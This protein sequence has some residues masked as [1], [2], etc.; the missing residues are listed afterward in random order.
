LLGK[1]FLISNYLQPY[2]ISNFW[3]LGRSSLDQGNLKEIEIGLDPFE[4]LFGS[5]RVWN[6]SARQC[7][8]QARMSAPHRRISS[9]S[10]LPPTP[11]R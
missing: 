11:H 5:N 6:R 1:L 3:R 9:H 8:A 2:F 7:A 10:S 4:F